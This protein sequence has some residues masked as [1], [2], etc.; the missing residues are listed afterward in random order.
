MSTVRRVQVAS[1][2]KGHLRT[3]LG[4]VPVR[5]SHVRRP[6][7]ALER[8]CVDPFILHRVFMSCISAFSRKSAL[9][10][11]SREFQTNA[12]PFDANAAALELLRSPRCL[13]PRCRLWLQPQR[14]C[15][16][17]ARPSPT[18]RKAQADRQPVRRRIGNRDR[19]AC[20]WLPRGRWRC[21]A[22]G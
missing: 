7:P 12:V 1:Q 10:F 2:K 3:R 9:R 16:L 4:P 17:T 22:R 15:S 13:Q 11:S 6:V 14:S 5:T 8:W 21:S 18:S 20:A 19:P